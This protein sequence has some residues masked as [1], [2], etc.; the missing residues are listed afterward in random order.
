M[1]QNNKN[2]S[3]HYRISFLILLAFFCFSPAWSQTPVDTW[4]KV[5][6]VTVSGQGNMT[7]VGR[8]FR[9]GSDGQVTG[10]NGGIIHSPGSFSMTRDSLLFYNEYGSADPYGAFRQKQTGDTI[11]WQRT[12][13][14]MDVTV[15]LI[16][17]DI[18]PQAP[19]DHI[20]GTW[21]RTDLPG[22]QV[23]MRW[24]REFR[25]RG[26]WLAGTTRGIWHI[27]AHNPELRL[28]REGDEPIVHVFTVAFPEPELMT[29]TQGEEVWSFQ[30]V[31][32]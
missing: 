13:E 14:G 23:Y 10:G 6:V 26:D 25:L 1:I 29:W 21:Q 32:E 16:P 27:R 15:Y 24:D 22:S 9:L 19:W 2:T 31:E 30:R 3:M 4:L 11:T 12:E 5:A 8:W 18:R 7:P 17:T 20:Q 28:I